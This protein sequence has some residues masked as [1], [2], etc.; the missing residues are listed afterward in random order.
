MIASGGWLCDAVE[1]CVQETSMLLAVNNKIMSSLVPQIRQAFQSS[2]KAP[3]R[4]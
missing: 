2:A 4:A 3:M 1:G